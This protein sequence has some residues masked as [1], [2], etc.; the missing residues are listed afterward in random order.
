MEVF[1]G[2][3]VAVGCHGGGKIGQGEERSAHGNFAGIAMM[4]GYLHCADGFVIVHMV[5]DDACQSGGITVFL[6]NLA[7]KVGVFHL[8]K[9][10]A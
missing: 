3:A 8:L 6:E 9:S 4:F 10:I 1:V 5:D 2:E 7:S